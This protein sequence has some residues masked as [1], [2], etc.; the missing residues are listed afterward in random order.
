[1]TAH[2]AH[3]AH[4]AHEEMQAS[5]VLLADRVT[6]LETIIL[7]LANEVFVLLKDD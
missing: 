7:K 2:D 3:D 6:A 1:M 5:I 4:D